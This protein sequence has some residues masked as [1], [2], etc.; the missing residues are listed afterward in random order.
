MFG[1]IASSAT[2]GASMADGINPLSVGATG[3]YAEIAARRLPVGLVLLFV[4][5]LAATVTRAEQLN[6]S[7]LNREE[8]LR[9]R[10][11]AGVLV[12]DPGP[13]RAVEERRGYAD[14][15]PAD[16]WGSWLA[17]HERSE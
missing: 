7:A 2:R 16:P 8:V 3:P 12:S 11:Q 10:D 14:L 5:R 13:A 9:I 17:L 1:R 15:D 4:P 6:G